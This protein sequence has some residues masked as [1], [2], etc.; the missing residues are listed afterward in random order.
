MAEAKQSNFRHIV[1]VGNTDLIGEKPLFLSLQKIKGVGENFAR[2]MCVLTK[3]DY[4]KTTGELDDKEVKELEKILENPKEAGV[5]LYYFN[6]LKDFETGNDNHLFLADLDFKQDQDIKRLKKSKSYIGL[7]HQWK[8]P[9]RGQRTQSN[10]RPNKGR[11][12][13]VKKKSSIRK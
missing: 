9:V 1:R 10:F 3:I 2:V 13:A 4:M 6:S 5:P 8:L 12:S 11:S 7:R